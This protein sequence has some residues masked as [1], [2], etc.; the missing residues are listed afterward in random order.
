MGQENNTSAVQARDATNHSNF[1]K[2][3]K[4]NDSK[5]L[6]EIVEDYLDEGN[7]T[8][9]HE[10]GNQRASLKSKSV[11]NDDNSHIVDFPEHAAAVME[12]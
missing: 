8:S 7:A 5:R 10:N 1:D 11:F 12:S 6:S 2:F 9:L 4:A 3:Y